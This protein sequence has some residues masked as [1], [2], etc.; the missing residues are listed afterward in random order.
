MY[1]IED[2]KVNL[3][4]RCNHPDC[5]FEIRFNKILEKKKPYKLDQI[6]FECCVRKFHNGVKH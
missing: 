1:K 5:N 2:K 6:V 4:I 3:S